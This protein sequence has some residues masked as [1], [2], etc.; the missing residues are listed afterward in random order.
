MIYASANVIKRAEKTTVFCKYFYGYKKSLEYK[1]DFFRVL[2]PVSGVETSLL[3]PPL[4]AFVISFFASMA[5][6]TGAFL[7]LPFQLIGFAKVPKH[8]NAVG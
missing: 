1:M 6:I 3:I 5:G 7:I 8:R 2:F 4:V